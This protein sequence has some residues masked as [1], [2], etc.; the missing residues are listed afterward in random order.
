[1]TAVLM[2]GGEGIR[3]SPYTNVL[4]KPL[5]PLDGVPILETIIR[6][7]VMKGIG[8]IVLAV[9]ERSYL[10]I[11]AYLNDGQRYGVKV[12]Y[13]V[14]SQ[15]LGTIGPLSIIKELPQ[16]FLVM[17]ADVLTTLD[18]RKLIE[19]HRVVGSIATIAAGT[20]TVKSE[21]GIMRVD[22]NG[23]LLEYQEKPIFNHLVSMGVYVFEKD[24]LGW[25][26]ENRPLDF[27]ELIQS[28]IE[29]GKPV[30]TYPSNEYWID[31]GMPEDYEEAQ[32][33]FMKMPEFAGLRK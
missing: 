6:Q 32:C 28:L 18:V 8:D 2:A 7:L 16:T 5:L 21:L 19:H 26:P 1:M 20:R 11:F 4:P 9:S 15:R 23:Y 12:R 22:G 31:I 24:V 10:P 29:S 13:S 3:L 17:N 33:D 14:E 27:P 30:S 25:I